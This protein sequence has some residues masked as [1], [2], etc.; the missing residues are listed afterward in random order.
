MIVINHVLL[1]EYN[2]LVSLNTSHFGR[3]SLNSSIHVI[4]NTHLHVHISRAV[5]Y[6]HLV[7][8]AEFADLEE[9]TGK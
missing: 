8:R 3:L 6:L 9:A 4:E 1:S 5:T 2:T 7:N